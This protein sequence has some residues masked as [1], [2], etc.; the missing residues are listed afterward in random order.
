MRATQEIRDIID[1]LAILESQLGEAPGEQPGV[2]AKIGDAQP[3]GAMGNSD[4]D[5]RARAQK[6]ISRMYSLAQNG[7]VDKGQVSALNTAMKALMA[8]NPLSTPQR[9][10]MLDVMTTLMDLIGD[11]SSLVARIKQDLKKQQSPAA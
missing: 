10:V 9:G 2:M 7:L 11:D 1:R 4:A 8:G 5:E 3:A 6:A